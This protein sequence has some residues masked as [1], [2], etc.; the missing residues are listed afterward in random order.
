MGEKKKISIKCSKSSRWSGKE[1]IPGQSPASPPEW[2]E[3]FF[4]AENTQKMYCSDAI[5]S[6]PKYSK[7]L[8]WAEVPFFAPPKIT[9]LSSHYSLNP[10]GKDEKCYKRK[11]PNSPGYNSDFF[12]FYFASLKANYWHINT[13]KVRHSTSVLHLCV[14]QTPRSLKFRIWATRWP[15]ANY[16]LSAHNLREFQES[17]CLKYLI[18]SHFITKCSR[19]SWKK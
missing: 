9:V 16:Q 2:G 10:G 12:F 4:M 19:T 11:D 14:L 17:V 8:P 6:R 5:I 7:F 1:H 15:S 18:I 3:I 13:K